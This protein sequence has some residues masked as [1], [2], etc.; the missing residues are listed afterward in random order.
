MTSTRC[1]LVRRNTGANC[2]CVFWVRV[3]CYVLLRHVCAELCINFTL[4]CL[5][6]INIYK[7][8][9]EESRTFGDRNVRFR[10]GM[11]VFSTGLAAHAVNFKV[12]V[13][14]RTA[15]R[16][17]STVP[18]N[19]SITAWTTTQSM[20]LCWKEI[21]NG[22]LNYNCLQYY[23]D[24]YIDVPASHGS[25]HIFKFARPCCHAVLGF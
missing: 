19:V 17:V 18:Y 7:R 21:S 9:A 16:R 20:R 1:I 15:P 25:R 22:E 23:T 24:I 8:W 2:S 5:C 6:K 14:S 13:T 4:G 10:Q 3:Q 11:C 12:I